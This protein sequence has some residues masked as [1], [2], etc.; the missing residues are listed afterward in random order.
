M[1][2]MFVQRCYYD[3]LWNIYVEAEW[4]DISQRHAVLYTLGRVIQKRCHAERV[5]LSRIHKG[6]SNLICERG[7]IYF[8]EA[9][10]AH[11]KCL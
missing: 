2:A 5:Q 1:L 3:M 6:C 11:M 9:I 8:N 4:K 7:I 10:T